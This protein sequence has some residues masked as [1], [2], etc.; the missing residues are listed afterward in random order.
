MNKLPFKEGDILF[1]T[2]TKNF[3]YVYDS[4]YD[5]S[6]V[7]T[8]SM[9]L[10]DYSFM[11]IGHPNDVLEDSKPYQ[12]LSMNMTRYGNIDTIDMTLEDLKSIDVSKVDIKERG[13]QLA[14]LNRDIKM[15]FLESY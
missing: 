1:N 8:K 2:L 6:T 11:V 9:Y 12:Y 10:I 14:K 7:H 3:V 5:V 13:L 15:K 4:K